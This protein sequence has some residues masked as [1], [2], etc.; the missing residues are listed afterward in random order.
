MYDQKNMINIAFILSFFF[1]YSLISDEIK[2]NKIEKFSKFL[3]IFM[4]KKEA[5]ELEKASEVLCAKI[6][7]KKT[8]F[9]F[10]ATFFVF[11]L[12]ASFFVSILLFIKL[13]RVFIY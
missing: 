2:Q 13:I 4:Q 3:Q 1:V 5:K 6:I 12:S 9:A 8:V 11:V 10:S 7:Y